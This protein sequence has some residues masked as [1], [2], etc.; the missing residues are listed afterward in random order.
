MKPRQRL[1]ALVEGTLAANIFDWGS[2]ECIAKYK[3]GTIL[4][5]YKDARKQLSKRPWRID[6]FDVFEEAIFGSKQGIP[7]ILSFSRDLC[8]L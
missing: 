7:L 3:E 4:S 1:L 8:T 2:Q 6:T 5:I